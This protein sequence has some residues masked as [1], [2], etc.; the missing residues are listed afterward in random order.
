M[1][2]NIGT[3]LLTIR[4]DRQLTQN[5]MAELLSMSPSAYSRLERNETKVPLED[6]PKFS[7]VLKIPVQDL[8]PEIFTVNNNPSGNASGIV[9]SQNIT[10]NY[11]SSNEQTKVLELKIQALEKELT[12]MRE[13]IK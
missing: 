1:N 7:E 4:E 5:E 10:Y 2:L 11:Y 12:E 13:K 3:R 6:L 8:L 9:M